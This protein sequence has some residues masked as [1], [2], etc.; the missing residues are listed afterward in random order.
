MK[1]GSRYAVRTCSMNNI[2]SIS[3]FPNCQFRL[4]GIDVNFTLFVASAVEEKERVS[5]DYVL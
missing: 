5:V 2:S 4:V 3:S 1:V